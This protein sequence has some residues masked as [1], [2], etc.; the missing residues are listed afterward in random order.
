MQTLYTFGIRVYGLI[1]R[2]ASLFNS[3]AKS[4]IKGRQNWT[5]KL[6]E[7]AN[8]RGDKNHTFWFHCASLGEYEQAL[9]VIGELKS[10]YPNCFILV[11][12]FSPSGYQNYK[13]N[14]QVDAICYLPLDT[15]G[16]AKRFIDILK[17]TAAYFVKYE[18][19]HNF[20]Q[21]IYRR[22]IPLYLVA[23]NF[24]PDQIYFK[25]YGSWFRKSLHRFNHIFV[26]QESN[27]ELL[28]SI[29]ITKVSVSGDT[30]IDRVL[31]NLAEQKTV[32]QALAFLADEKAII[33][34][35]AW[36]PE[37]TIL[38]S[39]LKSSA[40]SGKIIVAPHDV[41]EANILKISEALTGFATQRFSN[42]DA[43]VPAQIL[44]I[45]TIGQLR[46]LYA[47]SKLAFIGGGFGTG[48]HN[49]LEAVTFGIPVLFGPNI[50]NFPEAPALVQLKCAY[51]VSNAEEFGVQ[52][53]KLLSNPMLLKLVEE[54]SRKYVR[55]HS[56]AAK[57]IV[58]QI[59]NF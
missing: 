59:P 3:K 47:Y 20:I 58:D 11:S 4:W 7:I 1:I 45:D 55:D 54:M 28:K 24:R 18:I 34:G 26:Q 40:Y 50:Q 43:A 14:A 16:N 9:P 30:R 31:E 57:R 13:G 46:H 53:N 29:D 35:S 6:S 38:G 41:S 42:F 32:P 19:W 52:V 27:I 44:I 51:V 12:F 22:A 5:G 21:V 8:Q 17:P 33:L 48:L 39:W 56:G 10:D 23:A 15:I 49:I 37:V 25:G 2:L 36:E